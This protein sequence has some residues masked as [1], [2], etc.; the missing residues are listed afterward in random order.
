VVAALRD[1]LPD[2]A[3]VTTDAGN[4]GGWLARGYRFRRP[5]TF[6]GPTSGA[7]GYALPAAIAAA[8]VHRDRPVVAVA[9]D[10]G[11]AMTMTELET[12]VRERVRPIVLVFD[13]QRYGTIRMHQD[14]RAPGGVATDLGPID[15]VKA[16]EAFGAHGVRIEATEAFE[17]VLREALTADRPTVLHLVLDRSWVSVDEPPPA[18]RNPAE[19]PTPEAGARRSPVGPDDR[20]GGATMTDRPQPMNEPDEPAVG[21]RNVP[22]GAGGEVASGTENA[23]VTG[24]TGNEA[25][26][27]RDWG[28]TDAGQALGPADA[29]TD[30]SDSG[31]S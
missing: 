29:P 26:A 1:V 15:F 7:M 16:A 17:P 31:G 12:A 21:D 20:S 3:I 18:V 14:R 19:T 27:E 28:A 24:L 4:F 6:L 30:P 5:G 2:D 11:F 9:G 22:G 8:I 25:A 23:S 10:G 13:N